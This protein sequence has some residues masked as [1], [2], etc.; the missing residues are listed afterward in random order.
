MLK[1][2]DT[3]VGEAR[4][5]FTASVEDGDPEELCEGLVRQVSKLAVEAGGPGTTCRAAPTDYGS[6]I[7]QVDTRDG[8]T[9]AIK[10]CPKGQDAHR[11]RRALRLGVGGGGRQAAMYKKPC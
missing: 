11:S 1:A 10:K 9:E 5:L 3:L 6:I 2:W 7:V 8:S 4:C